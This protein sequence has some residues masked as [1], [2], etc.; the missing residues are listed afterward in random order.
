MSKVKRAKNLDS[1]Q[2]MA[3]F[4]Q[5][6]SEPRIELKASNPLELLVSTILSAQC[7]DER[8]NK[9][10]ESL[11]KK[12]RT[13][14]D[15]ASADLSE[16]ETDI[17][18]TGFYKN[19]AKNII[20]TAKVIHEEFKDKVPETIE[21]LTLLPG[22]GRK[23]ANVILSG[24]FK[25]PAVVVDTH[26]KRVSKRLGLTTSEDPEEIEMDLQKAF[27]MDKWS[28]ISSQILLFGRHFCKAKSPLCEGC[29]F[30]RICLS[31]G[32]W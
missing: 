25:K 30:N 1:I 32:E 27:P 26:V 14:R 21:E 10:T 9:V 11:F 31:Q 17:K 6:I 4:D 20:A 8:V 5:V 18:S 28:R 7:T 15:Y 29:L 24:W 12:Y 2:M 22:V 23:T 3:L 16:L 19:K 13:T